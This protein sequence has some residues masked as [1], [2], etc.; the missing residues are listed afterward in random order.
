MGLAWTSPAHSLEEPGWSLP[1]HFG[2]SRKE[3]VSSC[4]LPDIRC[5]SRLS[6]P[7][8]PLRSLRY[9]QSLCRA[10]AKVVRTFEAAAA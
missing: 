2:E 9:W 8:M 3:V 5:A 10:G 1:N 7:A 6:V 4:A